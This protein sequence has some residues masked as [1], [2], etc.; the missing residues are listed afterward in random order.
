MSEEKGVARYKVEAK[1]WEKQ[2]NESSPAFEAFAMYRDMGVERSH[3]KVAQA[4][5]KSTNLINTWGS[6]NK[7]A[8]RINAWEIEEDRLWRLSLG[9]ARRKM[10]ERQAMTASVMQGKVG[11]FLL[12]FDGKKL[13]ANEAARMLE[14]ASR[15]E[16]QVLGLPQRLEVTTIDGGD[17]LDQLSPEELMAKLREMK[18]KISE[19]L[20]GDE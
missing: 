7:W 20:G 4:L 10:A 8:S 3:A 14:V 12:E 18:G 2:P 17:A 15:I 6:K 1:P 5:G 11:Q 13:T 16:Q 19:A 9:T